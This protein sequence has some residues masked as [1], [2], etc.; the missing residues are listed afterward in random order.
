MQAARSKILVFLRHGQAV[1]NPRAEAAKSAGCSYER[2]LGLMREDDAFD[3]PLT[4]LGTSQVPRTRLWGVHPHP[5]FRTPAARVLG[6]RHP[7]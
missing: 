3:A 6:S 4:P 7:P 5:H 2:F 1:H